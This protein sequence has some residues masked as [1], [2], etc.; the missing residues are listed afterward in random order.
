MG[1]QVGDCYEGK[2]IAYAKRVDASP[3]N[4]CYERPAMLSMIPDIAGKAVLDVGCGSGWYVS[5]LLELGGIVT[6]V[7]LDADFVALTRERVGE[8]ASVFQADV[9]EPLAF[10]EDGSFGCIVAPL[11]LHY[12]ENWEPV[13]AEF[14]RVLEPGGHLVFST[15]HPTMDW[16]D[17]Q[18]GN[19]FQ[20]EL[21]EDEWDIGVVR[22]YRRSLTD[23]SKALWNAGFVIEELLEPKPTLAY[24]E[25]NRE[26]YER[27]LREP[28]FL[29]IRA[30]IPG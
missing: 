18:S 12:I 19:Y 4:A 14:A 29:V 24:A 27:L 6:A 13:L 26:W 25:I 2:A 20:Q 5:A 10:A 16:K 21:L 15:H 9:S 30:R 3:H 8:S 11:V 17:S 1:N 28:W 7:D 22:F 23:M